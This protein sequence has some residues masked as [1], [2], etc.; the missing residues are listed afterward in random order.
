[1]GLSRDERRDRL[2]RD[3][4]PGPTMG[5]VAPQDPL[6]TALFEKIKITD[7]RLFYV[8]VPAE[9]GELGTRAKASVRGPSMKRNNHALNRRPQCTGRQ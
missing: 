5:A 2:R 3:M 9:Y 7:A 4:F 6:A 8:K 1:M